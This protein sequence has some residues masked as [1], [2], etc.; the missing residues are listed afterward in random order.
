M[1]T[2]S[3][4]LQRIAQRSVAVDYVGEYQRRP[5]LVTDFMARNSEHVTMAA[6]RHAPAERFKRWL[7]TVLYSRAPLLAG[8]ALPSFYDAATTHLAMGFLHTA[9]ARFGSDAVSRRFTSLAQ[10]ARGR[11][12]RMIQ[13]R[14]KRARR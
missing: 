4:K 1:S 3:S 13:E 11:A 2:H 7:P 6:P 12:V 5:E 8:G 9:R 10:A 14:I